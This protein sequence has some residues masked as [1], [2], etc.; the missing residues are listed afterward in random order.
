MA[1]YVQ[2]DR[3][4][5][6]G[7]EGEETADA[8]EARDYRVGEG[9]LGDGRVQVDFGEAAGPIGCRVAVGDDGLCL[10]MR[11]LMIREEQHDDQMLYELLRCIKA[12]CT[13]EVCIVCYPASTA[14]S[15]A[16]GRLAK[17]LFVH[18]SLRPSQLSH[19]SF[20]PRKNQVI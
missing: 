19:H 15:Q 6:G 16:D 18:I 11:I 13:S 3:S 20:S 1:E 2:G 12:L 17:P 10:G 7:G 5:D 9:I 14:C 8:A 4:E